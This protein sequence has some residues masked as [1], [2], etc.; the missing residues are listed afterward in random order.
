VCH[1]VVGEFSPCGH[2][3]DF[4]FNFLEGGLFMAT[5]QCDNL[6]AM[7]VLMRVPRLS[8][9]RCHE[10][11]EAHQQTTPLDSLTPKQLLDFH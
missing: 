8:H 7:D 2:F 5:E 4:N 1:T 10:F 3:D 11:E 6:R 9:A